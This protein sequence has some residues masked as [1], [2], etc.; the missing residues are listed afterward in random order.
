ML[1]WIVLVIAGVLEAVWA[2]A[3]GKSDGL[4]K[5]T[6]TVIFIVA[7]VAS[8]IG[9]AYA[10]RTLP[11]GTSYAVWVGIGAVLTVSYAMLTGMESVSFLKIALLL[12]IVAGIVGLKLLH[13]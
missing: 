6:P 9:L 8:M 1:A 12:V 10:M 3:L 2:T 11:T 13:D 7:L 4:T 5:L